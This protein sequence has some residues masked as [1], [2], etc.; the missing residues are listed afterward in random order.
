MSKLVYPI[1]AAAFGGTAPTLFGLAIDL[2]VVGKKLPNI[3]FLLGLFIFAVI[4]AAVALI[5]KEQDCKR[6]F[7]LGIGLPALLQVGANSI[8]DTAQNDMSARVY[9][10]APVIADSPLSLVSSAVAQEFES[11]TQGRTVKV[12]LNK[13][14]LTEKLLTDN[15]YD[16]WFSSRSGRI[17]KRCI[18]IL[19]TLAEEMLT[20]SSE[21]SEFSNQMD[22][23]ESAT[24]FSIKSGILR[25][26]EVEL[27][28]REHSTTVVEMYAE[29]QAW[30]GFQRAIGI[31]G[32]ESYKI[33]I[34]KLEKEVITFDNYSRYIGRREERNYFEWKVFA[35]KP[36]GEMEKVSQVKYLLHPTFQQPIHTITDRNS[37][38][39]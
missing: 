3:S 17:E 26:N 14:L 10:T 21:M 9:H 19:P 31:K 20:K 36:A 24:R 12:F 8:T 34:R 37:S 22:V 6:A 27:S 25:S 7:Y 2:T 39:P 4:G 18:N 13:K 29:K 38:L 5:W 35:D 33:R 15:S 16:I 32:I 28:D 11:F 23:P 30:S 1:C